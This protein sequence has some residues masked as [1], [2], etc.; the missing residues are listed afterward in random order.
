MHSQSLEKFQFPTFDSPGNASEKRK[1]LT[2]RVSAL[3]VPSSV[4]VLGKSSFAEAKR[5][6][7]VNFE[8][9]SKVERIEE[10][11]FKWSGLKIDSGTLEREHPFHGQSLRERLCFHFVLDSS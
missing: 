9:R 5:L 6:E 1:D 2:N 7:I 10:S 11:A 8:N 4:V 3:L